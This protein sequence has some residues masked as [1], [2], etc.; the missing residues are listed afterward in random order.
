MIKVVDKSKDGIYSSN[1]ELVDSFTDYSSKNLDFDKPVT[2]ELLD[3]DE[4]AKNPLGMT[5]YY[6]PEEMKV[7]VYVTGRHLK[8]I[9]RSI[10]HELIH[11]VQ[12]CRGDLDHTNDTKLGYAQRDSHMRDMETEAYN[13]GNIMN[14]R[15]FEDIYKQRKHKMSKLQ[16]N[17][18][19]KLN[20]LL[21]GEQAVR[22]GVFKA[23]VNFLSKIGET[24]NVAVERSSFKDDQ[25][26]MNAAVERCKRK[27]RGF[28]KAV[29]TG[30]SSL[31]TGGVAS[32][33]VYRCVSETAIARGVEAGVLPAAPTFTPAPV[34]GSQL[35][36][37]MSAVGGGVIG[38]QGQTS[39][40]TA[41]GKGAGKGR[42]KYRKCSKNFKKRCEGDNIKTIQGLLFLNLKD[43]FLKGVKREDFVDG[44]FWTGTD[45]AVRAFQKANNLGV[46]GVVGTNT[47][48]K[49]TKN[50]VIAN[51]TKRLGAKT[52]AAALKKGQDVN[53]MTATTPGPDAPPAAR[54]TKMSR[55]EAIRKAT[56]DMRGRDRRFRRDSSDLAGRT[57]QYLIDQKKMSPSEAF[58]IAV[59]I[60]GAKGE[61]AKLGPVSRRNWMRGFLNRL[62]LRTLKGLPELTA[63]E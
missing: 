14:F 50:Q 48:E 19:K 26:R 38:G 21:M 55:F 53:K 31:G 20:G 47:L 41:T 49:L 33:D 4:N 16:E 3:D 44:K 17:R 10:S 8:D 40:A 2:I 6:S 1:M 45:K 54:P 27:N 36:P 18:L 23:F 22:G 12:N 13:S 39:R 58:N 35:A 46:D 32:A 15:D 57:V 9:L 56:T 62:E 42:I 11:H 30:R 34:G 61:K 37:A 25:A 63:A 60:F 43:T 59:D 51:L 52:V 7:V 29:N 5:A 28:T 24:D